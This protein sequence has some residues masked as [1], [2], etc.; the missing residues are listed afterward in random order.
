MFWCITLRCCIEWSNVNFPWVSSSVMHHDEQLRNDLK[1][2]VT[3]IIQWTIPLFV[4]WTKGWTPHEEYDMKSFI[5]LFSSFTLAFNEYYQTTRVSEVRLAQPQVAR[6]TNTVHLS[7]RQQRAFRPTGMVEVNR[8]T[9]A[10]AGR[11]AAS[12]LYHPDVYIPV[13]K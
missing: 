5:A 1:N 8:T 3:L 13:S 4:K 6:P 7:R 2:W 11:E 9:L 12:T 10:E